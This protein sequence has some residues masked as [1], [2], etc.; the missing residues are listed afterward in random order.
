MGD[1]VGWIDTNVFV[2]AQTT[3]GHSA[4]CRA[5]LH[6]LQAGEAR[7]HLDPVVVHE[8]TYALRNVLHWDKRTIAKYIASIIS[9]GTL[10]VAGGED[11][12][13]SAVAI[14][15]RENISFADALLASRAMLDGSMVCTENVR[16]IERAGGRAVAPR[17]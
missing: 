9:W 8:L 3:D 10:D 13:V 2:H 17:A 7:G 12:V 11:P 6:R 1:D 16:D 5:I 4:A 15:A 14:W